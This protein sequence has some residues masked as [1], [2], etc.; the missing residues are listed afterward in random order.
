MP[1]NSF[2]RCQAARPVNSSLQCCAPTAI[3]STSGR[4]QAAV[5][6][7]W[8]PSAACVWQCRRCRPSGVRFAE[9]AARY[10]ATLRQL[11]RGDE[12]SPQR[13]S[14][15]RRT[16]SAAA[17]IAAASPRVSGGRWVPAPH[18]VHTAAARRS[19]YSVR[20]SR[21]RGRLSSIFTTCADAVAMRGNQ[22]VLAGPQPWARFLIPQRQYA[23]KRV[24]SDSVAGSRRGSR[25]A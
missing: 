3:P 1:S 11:G 7:A 12:S 18:P 22:H 9:L 15:W 4:I 19:E 25:S 10:G 21:S 24:F 23:G 14:V 16:A 17:A 5:I 13:F 6:S 8:T 2:S 20:R